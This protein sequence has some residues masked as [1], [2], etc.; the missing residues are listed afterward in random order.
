MCIVPQYNIQVWLSCAFIFVM[1]YERCKNNLFLFLFASLRE[2]F[3]L[4]LCYMTLWPFTTNLI[5]CQFW[6]IQH[7]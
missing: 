6:L 2:N 3:R 7:V 5:Q 4:L 1:A